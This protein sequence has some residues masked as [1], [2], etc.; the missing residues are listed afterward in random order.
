MEMSVHCTPT[1]FFWGGGRE[2]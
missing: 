2:G 1:Q